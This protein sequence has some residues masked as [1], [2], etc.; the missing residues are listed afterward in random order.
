MKQLMLQEMFQNASK[1]VP[2][3]KPEPST[4]GTS[5]SAAVTSSAEIPNDIS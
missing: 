2:E 4:S 5:V 1:Q 3:P